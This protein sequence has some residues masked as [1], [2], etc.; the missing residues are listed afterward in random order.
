MIRGIGAAALVLLSLTGCASLSESDCRGGDWYNI[1]VRDGANGRGEDYV[2]EHTAACQKI[3]VVPDHDRWLEGRDRG[4]ERYCT[5]RNG[6]RVGEVGGSYNEVCFAGA[7]LEF[8]RGYELGLRMNQAKGKLE[9]IENEIRIIENTLNTKGDNLSDQ[10]K[11][12]LQYR[13]RQYE[14]DRGYLR[15]D[16]D[17]LEWRSRSF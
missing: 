4:L 6:Y 5:A 3:G 13:L 8:N 14:Y 7:E 12:Q 17:E 2:A 11:Q 15:R 16:V 10:E 9:R 1:G